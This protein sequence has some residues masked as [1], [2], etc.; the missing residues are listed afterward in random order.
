MTY[1][2]SIVQRGISVF[3]DRKVD[4]IRESERKDGV[5]LAKVKSSDDMTEYANRLDVTDTH[6]NY[7]D[8]PYFKANTF[9]KH[10]IALALELVNEGRVEID[11]VEWMW[12]VSGFIAFRIQ[13]ALTIVGNDFRRRISSRY[14]ERKNLANDVGFLA[15]FDDFF[16]QAI[17]VE[18]LTLMDDIEIA[19]EPLEI[20]FII[21]KSAYEDNYLN[22][23]YLNLTLKIGLKS[24]N[25][26]YF[27]KNLDR[28]FDLFENSGILEISEKTSLKV[29]RELFDEQTQIILE[30]LEKE[31]IL[32]LYRK[33]IN[34][35][36]LS[37]KHDKILSL[38]KGNAANI[39]LEIQKNKI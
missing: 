21:K 26:K 25:K 23:L 36:D 19:E 24:S 13:R 11:D 7:C 3:S 37:S 4:L 39:L 6:D 38:S 29:A 8:C 2:S 10:N 31:L 16:E 1:P 22:E 18:V 20:E 14:L 32:N 35:L 5:F 9:C 28:F 17:K 30:L 27:V 34:H 12:E 15:T 33:S